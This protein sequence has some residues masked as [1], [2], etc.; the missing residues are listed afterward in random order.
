MCDRPGEILQINEIVI[1]S[2]KMDR[3]PQ[4]IW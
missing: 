4:E 2:M 3:K 1:D